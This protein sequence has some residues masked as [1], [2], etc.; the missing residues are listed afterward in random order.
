MKKEWKKPLLTVVVRGL[1]EENVLTGCKTE[2]VEGA[3]SVWYAC[4]YD[5]NQCD[6][7]SNS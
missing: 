1:A 7:V 5:T 3:Y 2:S 6:N 4:F